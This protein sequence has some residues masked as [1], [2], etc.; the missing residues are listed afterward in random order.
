MPS[1]ISARCLSDTPGIA[2]GFFTRQ[3][4]VSAGIYH[5]LNCGPGSR[6]DAAAVAEN[7]MRVALYLGAEPSAI[8]TL[9]QVHGAD[10]VVVDR[11]APREALPKADAVVTRTPGLVVGVLTADCTPVLLAD[12]EALRPRLRSLVLQRGPRACLA[13]R[14]QYT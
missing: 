7:R 10:A 2:H 11:P 6:D 8:V 4:G 13:S 9:Y 1:P 3:G 12:P 5:A 14:V